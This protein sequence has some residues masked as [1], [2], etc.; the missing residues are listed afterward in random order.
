MILNVPHPV[1]HGKGL[2]PSRR[3]LLRSSYMFFFQLPWLP[4]RVFL[5][6]ECGG[7]A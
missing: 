7:A 1:A 5:A 2:Q 6:G 4:E 3:Q